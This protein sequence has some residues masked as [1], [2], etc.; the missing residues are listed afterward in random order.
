MGL[1]RAT[2]SKFCAGTKQSGFVPLRSELDFIF[3]Q[4]KMSVSEQA[5]RLASP[6][7]PKTGDLDPEATSAFKSLLSAFNPSALFARKAL[8]LMHL[9]HHP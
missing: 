2:L 3:Q 5:G 1:V 4:E 9:L 8:G 7:V 6:L